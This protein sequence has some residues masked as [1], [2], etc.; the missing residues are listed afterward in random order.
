MKL[1]D[2]VPVTKKTIQTY[3]TLYQVEY[4]GRDPEI[5]VLPFVLAGSV[6]AEKLLCHH[7]Q[8]VIAC[9][10]LPGLRVRAGRVLY[11]AM[12]EPHFIRTL[13]A[14]IV[15]HRR[16]REQVWTLQSVCTARGA[17]AHDADV[18][19]RMPSSSPR[20]ES[21]TTVVYGKW[22]VV[23]LYRRTDVGTQPELEIGRILTPRGFAYIPVVLD[24][25][26]NDLATEA[27]QRIFW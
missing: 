6:Y 5:Y 1:F 8:A 20:D 15:R 10:H 13:V 16:L 4:A 24:W 11:D 12:W 18:S 26:L 21:N 25:L 9:F 17:G 3:L 14:T 19:R 7:Q 22:G 27:L 23:K 2:A